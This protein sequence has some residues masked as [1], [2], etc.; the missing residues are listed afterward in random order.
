MASYSVSGIQTKAKA[1]EIVQRARRTRRDWTFQIIEV[2]GPPKSW[3]V[4]GTPPAGAAT[5]ESLAAAT[6]SSS[7]IASFL[8]FIGGVES[9]G[10]YNAKYGSSGNEDD[11]EFIAMSV[12]EVIAWQEGIKLDAA[13][14]YQIIE[15]TLKSLK[16]QMS[17][18]G[19]E[20]FDRSMQD[21]MAEVLLK[22]RG[23][24]EYL[25]GTMSAEAFANS[26][27]KEWAA[28]PV[29]SGPGAGKSFYDGD[30]L[31]K[32]LIEVDAYMEA[33]RSLAV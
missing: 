3:T 27:A 4:I 5:I 11:P 7:E 8:D 32:A 16:D 25:G 20:R 29:V 12:D 17:L 13:G 6:A 19:G 15:K 31:N 24:D 23:L 30:G 14:K 2:S 22:R 26:V 10:N 33:V 28:F 9:T 18:S 21:A 1:Q